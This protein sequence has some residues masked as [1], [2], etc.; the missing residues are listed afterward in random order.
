[1]RGPFEISPRLGFSPTKPHAEAGIRM[2]P[3]P[4][5][6][7]ATG[8]MCDATAA[9]APPDDPPAE[10]SRSHGVRAGG[11]TSGSVYGGRPIS[12][13]LV[14]PTISVPASR[15]NWTTPASTGAT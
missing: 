5:E 4:S 13:V 15:S 14:L 7:W 3:P 11:A 10:R 1:S 6:A 8:T 2:D 9:A 12:G